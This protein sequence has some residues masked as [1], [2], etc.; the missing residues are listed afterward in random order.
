MEVGGVAAELGMK[1]DPDKDKVMVGGRAIH[2]EEFVY[3]A[4]NKPKGVMSTCYDRY[5][6]KTVLDFIESAERIY[7][8][9]RLDKESRGLM[10]L[11]NDGDLAHE[12]THPKFGHEKEY[13]VETEKAVS[14]AGLEKLRKG[15]RLEEG[16]AVAKRAERVS[17]NR[18]SIVL[19]QGWKRQI[20]RMVRAMG[21]KVADLQRV[22]IGSLELGDLEEGNFRRISP[23]SIGKK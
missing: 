4:L 16:I 1:I 11:T 8:V 2:P 18:F 19:A 7:P 17:K 12:L 9:G 10:I 3:F 13:L 20:R 14:E 6:D 22:R 23:A 21:H 15:V 5:A